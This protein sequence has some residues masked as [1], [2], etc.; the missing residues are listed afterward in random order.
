MTDF[1]APD[2]SQTDPHHRGP[3]RR[4]RLS[5]PLVAGALAAST[6]VAG[7]LSAAGTPASAATA[8]TGLGI[9]LPR[10]S[11]NTATMI[12]LLRGPSPAGQSISAM[13]T[14]AA[15]LQ[16][17]IVAGLKSAGAQV[18][19]T[20]SVLDAVI[21]DVTPAQ[22]QVLAANPSVAGV[23]PDS[24]IPAPTPAGGFT[25]AAA[26]GA[27]SRAT[28]TANGKITIPCGTAANP[29]LDPE[30][31]ANINY[32][33][34]ARL[35]IDGKGVT[36]AF[37]AGS[38][39]TTNADFQRNAAFGPAGT[40]V[41]TSQQD[42]TGDGTNA[43]GGDASVEAFGDASSIAAQGNLVFNLKNFDNPA[44][45]ILPATCDL[46]VQGDAPGASLQ[47]DVIFPSGFAAG[48]ATSS[49]FIQAI[50]YATTHD[51]KV[52]NESFGGNPFPDTSNDLTRLA[53]DA[54]VAAGVTVVV[55]TGDSG[56]TNTQQ[57][58]ASDPNVVS[59]GAS[60][61]FRSYAQE[62]FGGISWPGWNGRWLD[63][64]LSSISSSGVNQAGRTIDLVAPGDLNWADCSAN[65]A[66]VGG[67]F[68][69]NWQGNPSGLQ[70]FGGTSESSPLI[71]GAAADVIQAY[72]R[73]H[74]GV[75]PSPALVKQ[76]LLS[77]ATDINAPAVEQGAGLLNIGAAVQLAESLPGS[78]AGPGAG[79]LVSPNQINVQAL[80]STP[81]SHTITL[82]NLGARSE[83]VTLSTRRLA[84]AP[85]ST[86]QGSFC[87]NPASAAGCPAN[88]GSFPI[89]SG[90]IEEYQTQTFD[91]PQGAARLEFAADYPFTGQASLLHFALFN[92][93]GTYSAYSLPQGVGDY[94]E[95][96]VADPAA[97][98]WTAVF[99][100][101]ATSAGTTG[102]INWRATT[103]NWTRGDSISPSSVTL[104]AGS[105]AT[106][107]LS[108]VTP[109][110][111][112]DSGESVVV[113]SP[114]GT[115]TIP[116][117]IRTLVPTGASG[118]SFT[119]IL[120]GGNGRGSPGGQ[121][122]QENTYEFAVPTGAPSLN[123]D[124]HMTS[125]S[126]QGLVLGTQLVGYLIDP[127]GAAVAYSTNYTEG[128]PPS[129]T[130]EATT[131]VSLY[132]AQPVSGTWRLVLDWPNP[133]SGTALT[134]PFT[135]AVTFAPFALAGN[136][137]P[138]SASTLIT[139]G[140]PTPFAVT[141][142]N[143]SAAPQAFFVDPRL[144]SANGAPVYTKYAMLNLL[145]A[146]HAQALGDV[147]L[148]GAL[149][150]YLVPP[151]TREM[152]ASI[153]STVPV[154]FD[155]FY[156]VGDPDVS[157]AVRAPGVNGSQSGDEARLTF[158]SPEI[159][160]G[161]WGLVPDEVGPYG[162]AGIKT[163][164]AEIGLGVLTQTFD[165]SVS[166]TAGDLWE[167]GGLRMPSS[168]GSPLYLTPAGTSSAT[169]CGTITVTIDPTAKKGTVIRGTLYLDDFVLGSSINPGTTFIPSDFGLG[170]L[171]SGDQILAIPYS[172]K[173]G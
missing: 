6:A 146:T 129:N 172:Y 42:F 44:Y 4:G 72:A 58:P 34:A 86:S 66:K 165:G 121:P 99:F 16:A 24:S 55:S 54:A 87:M 155:L 37:L 117:T 84:T 75:D 106:A 81:S 93:S 53:N 76:I 41:I 170:I 139:A 63:N 77:T 7:A 161:L 126:G 85:S 127:S 108:V 134:V 147:T 8:H 135:G 131:D 101:L 31:L 109:T 49:G 98:K 128:P 97:G 50:N 138:N 59:A 96:E 122:G 142:C 119:G 125:D 11:G 118:G 56:N 60:T 149:L 21:A 57:S 61:T 91:V 104:A 159:G 95:V 123:V 90:V 46:K 157:P 83:T 35:G 20:T 33:G 52:I 17:P 94:G 9:V 14:S 166:S 112:G 15:F 148:P 103:W 120:S 82:T 19:A 26:G 78:S 51:V 168:S 68:C 107:T 140:T 45:T 65:T 143:P 2:L 113:T 137:V 152:R 74:G 36:V 162:S 154:T 10:T 70:D 160:Q 145:G 164:N 62:N 39:D 136:T 13:E 48:T 100:T 153:A 12:V 89:W 3:G 38:I 1:Q 130:P 64:N 158:S 22:A 171:P 111:A 71:A 105:S 133:V 114:T 150:A 116:V 169:N 144:D 29:E 151:D 23:F 141:V 132:R 18:L 43:V 102:T 5:R 69:N 124:I 32:P 47:S 92:P 110:N 79:S 163:V 25:S 156:F 40:P 115:N 80:P 27:S 173:V 73:T 88:T 67:G 28:S 30:A 167:L